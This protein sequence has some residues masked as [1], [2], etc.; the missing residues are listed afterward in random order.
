[1]DK[2]TTIISDIGGVILDADKSQ[3]IN[4]FALY[5]PLPKKELEKYFKN[6]IFTKEQ[7][8]FGIGGISAEEFYHQMITLL[9]IRGMDF[10][11]FRRIYSCDFLSRKENVI[12]LLH[13]LN[14]KYKL[15]LLSNT[16]A[17]HT[18]YWQELLGNDMKLFKEV[19]LSFEVHKA[20]PDPEIFRIAL[21]KLE[22]MPAECIY[23]DDVLEYVE[24]ARKL[25]IN[26][27]QFKSYRQ[28]KSDFK[29]LGVSC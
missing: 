16:D 8:N 5:S 6:R 21:Q 18:E 10:E 2:I 22:A 11:G 1:M 4:K 20:K 13:K 7:L 14:G 19:I 26:A 25:G 24:A 28:L 29:K 17:L 15:A 9:K 27:I 3:M 12:S 23:I